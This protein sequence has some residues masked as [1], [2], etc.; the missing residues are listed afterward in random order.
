MIFSFSE[1]KKNRE[2]FGTIIFLLTGLSCQSLNHNR[3]FIKNKSHF[4]SLKNKKPVSIDKN[5]F[6][7]QAVLNYLKAETAFFESD[8]TTAL[9]YLKKARSLAPNS[10]HFQKRRAEIYERE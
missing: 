7:Y 9:S 8:F 6:E 3:T 1:L 5:Y 10:I 4:H 2:I